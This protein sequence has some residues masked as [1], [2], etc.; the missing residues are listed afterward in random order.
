MRS[1]GH[2]YT[3]TRCLFNYIAHYYTVGSTLFCSRYPVDACLLTLR[4][5]SLERGVL[6][7]TLVHSRF[8]GKAHREGAAFPW[9][10]LD[11]EASTEL[12]A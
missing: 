7:P 12:G 10:A 1:D 5:E 4:E 9:G 8:V 6:G 3:E 11:V 2:E